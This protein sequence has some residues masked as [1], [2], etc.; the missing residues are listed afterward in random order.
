ME[1]PDY[2]IAITGAG[3]VGSALALLL[4]GKAPK[5]KR[6]A[7]IGKHFISQPRS[8]AEQSIDPRTLALNHG[9]RVLLEQLGAWPAESASIETVHVSQR[10]RLGRTL[11]RHSELEVPRL[12]SVVSY[13]ALLAALHLAVAQSGIQ[14]I[15]TPYVTPLIAHHVHLNVG[16]QD[17]TCGVAVQ[18][19]GARPKGITRDYNQ[20]AILAT[21]RASRPRPRWAYERF[22][23]QG[24]LAL[25]PHPQG[26]DLYGVVWC[27]SPT[28]AHDLRKLDNAAFEAALHAMF[29]D[30][31][32]RFQC[33]NTRH[34]FP[35][36]LHAGSMRVNSRTV[37]IGNAAQTLHPVAGQGLNLGLRDAV[38]L[39]QTLATWLS[40]PLTDPSAVLDQFI[41]QRRPDRWLTTGV[42][43]FLPRVFSTRN[44]LIEHASGLSLLAMDLSQTI[45]T[46][47]ARHLLQGLRT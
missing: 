16:E 43:D 20:Y 22:T 28:R 25:L 27:C 35:L 8:G 33:A 11:I 47:L 18:S 19:D 24:P 36:S 15:E 7:L 32:G 17:L 6:I 1:S 46:P 45:R 39:S 13:D 10:G 14:L 30:R 29:G 3:P 2:D 41:R 23:G 38:Q 5:P 4:A 37:A 21:V 34:V 31:L 40:K 42:T 9:S 26:S 12:G 44:P